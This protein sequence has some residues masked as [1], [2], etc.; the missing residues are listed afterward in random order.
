MQHLARYATA[1]VVAL[2]LTLAACSDESNPVGTNGLTENDLMSAVTGGSG[3]AT[4]LDI[5]YSP[6][7]SGDG[8]NAFLVTVLRGDG[9]LETYQYNSDGNGNGHKQLVSTGNNLTDGFLG[10]ALGPDVPGKQNNFAFCQAADGGAN[11]R[12]WRGAEENPSGTI[13]LQRGNTKFNGE[14][15]DIDYS[16]VLSGDGYNAFLVTVDDGGTIKTY[17]YNSDGNGNGHRQLVSTGNHLTNGFLGQALG[18][19]VPGKQNNFAFCRDIG[20]KVE[21]WRGAEENPSSTIYLQR[22]KYQIGS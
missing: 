8:Y 16:P 14:F 5:D 20:S 4:F 2:T 11:T 15:L 12:C 10:Q 17:Q 21:C 7:L 19:D 22:G 18:P 6:V 3:D 13:Y 1:L 9:T